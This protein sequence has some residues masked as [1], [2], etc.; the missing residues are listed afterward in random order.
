VLPFPPSSEYR[1][2]VRYC[3][4]SILSHTA[5]VSVRVMVHPPLESHG[6]LVDLNGKALAVKLAAVGVQRGQSGDVR[7]NSGLS[8]SGG[9]TQPCV[10]A[11]KPPMVTRSEGRGKAA[12]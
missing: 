8:F 1:R 4:G 7:Q 5:S 6:H 3:A 9:G 10:L 11:D 2:D 12:K